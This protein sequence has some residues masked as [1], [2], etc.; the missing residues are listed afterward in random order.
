MIPT[1]LATLA[2]STQGMPGFTNITLRPALEGGAPYPVSHLSPA[3]LNDNAVIDFIHQTPVYA[4]C[5][6]DP[7]FADAP[8]LAQIGSSAAVAM[9]GGQGLYAATSAGLVFATHTGTPW[10]WSTQ[11][12]P[13]ATGDWADAHSLEPFDVDGV[14]GAD[15]V[16]V[17]ADQH[18]ILLATDSGTGMQ[19]SSQVI[20]TTAGRIDDVIAYRYNLSR[21][22][23][24]VA[25]TSVGLEC[26]WITG[27]AV[28]TVNESSPDG[29]L[30]V[31]REDGVP[32]RFAWLRD[33]GT[34]RR[35]EIFDLPGA[36]ASA[37]ELPNWLRT[38]ASGNY[39]SD[40]Y[41]DLVFGGGPMD[42]GERPIQVKILQQT[43]SRDFS[44]AGGNE[45]DHIFASVGGNLEYE[46]FLGDADGDGDGDVVVAA[47]DGALH[48]GLSGEIPLVDVA[49]SIL[50]SDSAGEGSEQLE[51]V[52]MPMPGT[53]GSDAAEEFRLHLRID[54]SQ[55]PPVIDKGGV[56]VTA[57]HIEWFIWD[58]HRSQLGDEIEF[59]TASDPLEF[60]FFDLDAS[61]NDVETLPA[62]LLQPYYEIAQTIFDSSSA[63]GDIRYVTLRYVA[64]ENGATL[65]RWPARQFAILGGE[66]MATYD[67]I[68]S[69]PFI[70]DEGRPL[71]P[72][73]PDAELQP[74]EDNPGGLGTLCG[75][76]CS[77][78]FMNDCPPL[79]PL[80]PTP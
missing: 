4:H 15:L 25:S 35:L 79:P 61:S 38:M 69:L 50:G 51:H 26:F 37:L 53:L 78:D 22:A 80:P 59:S 74:L 71:L 27:G 47:P 77:G 11:Q 29:K 68:R 39:N 58:S 20:A 18:G 43:T 8:V 21:A 67:Y 34:A 70:D 60:G 5:A 6:I 52:W 14:G 12:A 63:G 75:N 32:D 45:R 57:T 24:I 30:A 62:P 55:V 19:G 36:P 66:D 73:E 42:L 44:T 3:D 54:A 41:E 46:P 48:L 1:L 16:G 64:F 40:R 76:D 28:A 33:E 2:L 7:S 56:P 72:H 13:V 49:P 9:P 23:M 17:T 31:L 10:V 65:V